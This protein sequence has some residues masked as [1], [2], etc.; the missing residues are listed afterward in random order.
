MKLLFCT[1]IFF[2]HAFANE[3]VVSFLEKLPKEQILTLDWFFRSS[4]HLVDMYCMGINRY[5]LKATEKDQLIY[6][7]MNGKL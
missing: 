5:A 2:A 4:M 3:L 7:Q 1:F 6:I